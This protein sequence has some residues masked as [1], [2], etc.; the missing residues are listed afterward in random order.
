[1]KK[2]AL[3]LTALF[4]GV[5]YADAQ[6]MLV[7]VRRD[8]LNCKIGKLHNEFYPITFLLDDT[9]M[10]GQIH[11]DSVLYFRKGVF[12]GLYDN[13]L[14]PWYSFL[15]LDIDAGLS[16]QTGTFRIEEQMADKGLFSTRSG[17]YLGA[18]LIYWVSKRIGYG[19]RYDYRMLLS[20]DLNYQY[21]GPSM[22]FRFYEDNR[23]NNVYFSFS[24][25][26][27]WMVQ[28][29]AYIDMNRADGALTPIEM[30]ANA[31]SGSVSLAYNYRLAKNLSA[32]A[33]VSYNLGYPDF[34]RVQDITKLVQANDKPLEL[35][36]YCVSMNTLNLTL[37]VTFHK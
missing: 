29:N 20:G 14:R 6:D 1:M 17:Y 11:V 8:T 35:D 30:H 36:G 7:T 3:L 10:T 16:N 34:I 5:C 19:L 31:L 33:K 12:R 2:I 4:I 25:G 18:D 15:D 21:V 27:G 22:S 28:K 32:H 13:R 9:T 23:R 24:A 26:Y 37:G